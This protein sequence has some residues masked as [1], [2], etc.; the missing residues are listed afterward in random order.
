MIENM[1][2]TIAT[3]AVLFIRKFYLCSRISY[4]KLTTF[5]NTFAMTC[6]LLLDHFDSKKSLSTK[7]TKIDREIIR[8]I[9]M[10]IVKCGMFDVR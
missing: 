8:N 6:I 5:N 10:D 2:A 1:H 9:H 7:I 4:S 3:F